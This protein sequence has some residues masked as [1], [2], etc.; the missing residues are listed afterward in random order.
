MR[1]L[2]IGG[3]NMGRGIATRLASGGNEL[4][5]FD[6]DSAKAEAIASELG[7]TKPGGARVA[8]AETPSEAVPASDVVILASG[9]GSNL[10][11]VRKPGAE[12][13][14][15]IVVDISNPLDET[16]DGLATEPGRLAA[17][18][19]HRRL[20]SGARGRGSP[21]ARSLVD[22][23]ANTNHES[24]RSR[25]SFDGAVVGAAGCVRSGARRG[26]H[27]PFAP[28]SSHQPREEG[29]ESANE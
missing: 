14:G 27:A 6:I 29:H 8:I 5:L 7:G 15:K 4:T 23:G 28:R 11:V 1:V 26:T 21:D 19:L 17:E 3:G 13:G 9:Y 22:T 25:M 18:S 2:I 12:L 20:P 24:A 10:D 16:S